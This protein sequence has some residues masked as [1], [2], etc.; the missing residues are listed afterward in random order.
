[1]ESLPQLLGAASVGVH[2][3]IAAPTG[4]LRELI[5]KLYWNTYTLWHARRE[6]KLPYLPLDQILVMRD[7]RF[8]GMVEHA[9]RTVPFYRSLLDDLRLV[10]GDL[11]TADELAK[12]PVVTGR[13]LAEQPLEFLSNKYS[14][15]ETLELSTTGTTGQFKRIFFDSAALF[16]AR[17]AGLRKRHA[18]VRILGQSGTYRELS[19]AREGGT[20]PVIRGFYR[21]RSWTPQR[22]DLNRASISPADSFAKNIEAINT[23]Q[24]DV[25]VGFGAYIGAIFRFALENDLEIFRPKAIHYGGDTLRAPDGRLIKEEYRI[26][27]VSSFQT[28]EALNIAFQCENREGFHISLDQVAVR[29]VD[30]QGRDLVPGTSGDLV[31]SNLTNRATVLLNYR[32]GD[33]VTLATEPCPCGRTLPLIETLDGRS[34]DL[35]LRP[36][37]ELAHESVILSQLYDAPGLL[38]LQLEQLEL[39]RFVLRVVSRRDVE[40]SET[41]SYLDRTL[42]AVLG[43]GDTVALTIDRVDDIPCE[44]SGK[45]KAIRSA[46]TG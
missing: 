44:P 21:D 41:E 17:A 1:M 19:V 34:E 31:V 6:S 12:L 46:C 30:G 5:S 16:Q 26:P 14:V 36:G 13:D 33:K 8:R 32:L 2:G 37:G 38:L 10:P 28:C 18:L 4:S 29:V 22:F 7:R 23:F 42:R 27:V 3:A 24:P 40:W 9:Y 39:Q 15:D 45:F 25:I 35:I 43:A 20:F 11:K